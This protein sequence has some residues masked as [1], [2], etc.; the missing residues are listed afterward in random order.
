[1]GSGNEQQVYD[2]G[3]EGLE[4]E[5]ASY[6]DEVGQILKRM[7]MAPGHHFWGYGNS[8]GTKPMWYVLQLEGLQTY[9]GL[10]GVG[11]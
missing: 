3:A 11:P 10:K 4:P 9:M 8:R 5:I 7:R 1:M 2:D 6:Y